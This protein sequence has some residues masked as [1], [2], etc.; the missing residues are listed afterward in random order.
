[1]HERDREL[2][3]AADVFLDRVDVAAFLVD[4]AAALDDPGDMAE[5][6]H[7]GAAEQIAKCG[8][9]LRRQVAVHPVAPEQRGD[10]VAVGKVPAG[11]VA[12][13]LVVGR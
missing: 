3:P 10:A 13:G 1:M 4:D 7:V 11:C 2:H 8:M 12:G 5:G 6:L 9:G